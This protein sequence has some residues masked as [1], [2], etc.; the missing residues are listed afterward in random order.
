MKLYTKAGDEGQ[1]GLSDGTRVRKDHPR[2][3]SCGEVDELNALLGW[4][5]CLAAGSLI[6]HLQKIQADLLTLGSVLA[7]PAGV[8]PPHVPS[9]PAEAVRRLELWIDEAWEAL[10]PLTRFVLPGGTELSCRLHIARTC[11]RRVERGVVGLAAAELVDREILVYLNR[12]SDL[13]FAW[14]RQ[15]N[16]NAQCPEVQWLPTR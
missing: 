12:L 2:L 11:C 6:S 15:A 1:T 10:P 3:C 13:L 5:A 4:C 16:F 9:V 7:T 8:R 14:A